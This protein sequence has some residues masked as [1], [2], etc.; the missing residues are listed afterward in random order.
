MSDTQPRLHLHDSRTRSTVP[1]VP[2]APDNVRVYYCGPTVYDLA[3]IGNLR[4]ML[5]ADVL[6]RLLRHLYKR[7]TYV[8]NITDVDD[9]INARAHANGE[10]I[11]DLTARTIHDFHEDLAAVSILPPDVE[12]RATHHIGEMQDMIRRLIESGHAYE[13]EGHVLFAVNTYPSYGALSGRTPDDLIAG[14]R[15]EVA[16]YKRDPGDFVLWKPSDDQTP[17]WDSP[18]GRGRPGWHIECSAMS[19]RYLGESFDIHGG[20]SDLLFPHHENERAQSMCCHPHGRFANHW[21]HNAMLLVNG[22][23]MSKSLGNF[24][25]VRD[26]LRDTPA[27]ALRLLLLRAQY[28]SVLNFTREG[29]NEARQMLDRFYRALENLDPMQDAVPAPDSVVQVLCDDLNTP[30]ALAEMHAL[31]DAAM[32]GDSGAAAQLKAAGNLIGLLQDTPEAWFRG[33]A[34]VDP[35]HIERLIAERLAARKARDFARADEI[36]N[37]LAAQGIVLEDGPQGTTWRQA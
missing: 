10:S 37:D 30:R 32:A 2:L 20:G 31:A 23:K 4:A 7:V 8:R 15:V 16:P 6:V 1:F 22:E 35:A 11:A 28:R 19:Q 29:L 36:R 17:G 5:T 26:V 21:V 13:A 18:W 3:H 34:K 12:P 9:K 33:D 25:T 24:L 27:E 14:A